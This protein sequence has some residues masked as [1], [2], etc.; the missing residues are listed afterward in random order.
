MDAASFY[1]HSAQDISVSSFIARWGRN[2]FHKFRDKIKKYQEVIGS[3]VNRTDD[4][5]LKLYFDERNKI[6][7]LLFHEEVYWKQRAKTFWLVEGDENTKFFHANASSKRKTNRIA[8]LMTDSGMRVEDHDVMCD[9]VKDYFLSVFTSDP[10]NNI[11]HQ[12]DVDM[13]YSRPK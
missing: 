5:A 1:S 11:V 2:F 8:Y 9:V 6:N 13:Y 12:I 7:E 3:L 4:V 10:I